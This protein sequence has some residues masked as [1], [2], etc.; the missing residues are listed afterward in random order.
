MKQ[1]ARLTACALALLLASCNGNGPV[2]ADGFCAL[3]RPIYV[4]A[5]D[6]LTDKTAEAV[7]AHNRTWQRECQR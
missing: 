3:A 5:G 7:L 4:S 6:V 1:T 2:T